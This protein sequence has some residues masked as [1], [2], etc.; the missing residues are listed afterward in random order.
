MEKSVH[1]SSLPIYLNLMRYHAHVYLVVL[2]FCVLLD[3]S[4]N[5]CAATYDGSPVSLRINTSHG[6]ENAQGAVIDA[7]LNLTSEVT[8]TPS[9]PFNGRPFLSPDKF[10]ADAEAVGAKIMASSFSGWDFRY[11]A[12]LYLALAK[13]QMLHVFAYEPRRPQPSGTPP[14]AVF[15][16]V[17]MLGG[18]S[19]PGIE[20]GVPKAYMEGKGQG[21]S[22]SA[23]TAQLAGLLAALK[24]R[25]PE[26]NWFDVKAALRTTATNFASGYDDTRYGY[27]TIDYSAANALGEAT[28]LPL[29][30]PAAVMRK[31][32]V[33]QVTFA[34]NSFKQSR[35]VA[36]TLF[37]FRMPPMPQLREMSLPEITAIGGQILYTGDLSTSSN[38]LSLR[39]LRDE[40]VYFVWL[41]KDHEGRYSRIEPYSI[42][43]P[44]AF[45][46]KKGQPFGPR[47]E[48]GME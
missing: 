17:N 32:A 19:G 2:L 40:T 26:W 48:K 46:T 36:D 41:T 16:T 21:N 11:D 47:R 45:T 39:L 38:M 28:S 7:G 23:V 8:V 13:K 10:I 9:S 35:R 3:V 34:V 5:C 37:K 44:V 20:F 4:A 18:K 24:Y 42:I 27:G 22:P 14:P 6:L 1:M 15:A 43:G 29:F 25:H 30:P 31:K 33:D 12:A